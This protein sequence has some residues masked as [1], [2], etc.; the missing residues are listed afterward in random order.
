MRDEIS[1][2]QQTNQASGSSQAN[3]NAEQI[4]GSVQQLMGSALEQMTEM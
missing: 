3:V 2:L 1:A 4:I